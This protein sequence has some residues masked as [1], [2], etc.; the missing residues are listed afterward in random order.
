MRR[1]ATLAVALGCAAPTV[2]LP[3]Q[4]AIH[5]TVGMRY[6][7]TLVHDSI[8]AA[9]DVRPDLAPV[10]AGALDLPLNGPWRLELL[11]DV[12][13]SSV[14][15]HDADGGTAPITRVWMVGVGVGLRRHLKPWL[16]GRAAVGGLKYLPTT[17][18]GLFAD[19]GGGVVPFGSL[20]FDVSPSFAARHRVALEVGGDL[21]RFLTPT[22]RH[23]GFVDSRVVYRLT[24]GVRA[25]LWKGGPS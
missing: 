16:D 9:L 19:G 1:L 17:A 24:L 14:R 20:A 11:V 4:A 5:A 8:L 2:R 18:V 13:T 6:T 25:G 7:S 22:L 3:A 15:R 21:H 23:A 12:S 10:V